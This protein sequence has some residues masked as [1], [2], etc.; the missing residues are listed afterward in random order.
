MPGD[1]GS[2][3]ATTQG[4][5]TEPDEPDGGR[6][7]DGDRIEDER[8]VHPIEAAESGDPPRLVDPPH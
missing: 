5:D 3:K 1:C 6:L 4:G 7:G 8:M 2:T